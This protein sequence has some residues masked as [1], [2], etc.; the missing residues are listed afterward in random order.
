MLEFDITNPIA[1]GRTA[2]IFALDERYVLKLFL[3]YLPDDE[4][5]NEAAL[6]R[7]V[8]QAGVKTPAAVEVVKVNGRCGIVMERI[9]GRSM[10]AHLQDNLNE[11]NEFAQALAQLHT[12]LHQHSSMTLVPEHEW[13]ARKI[14]RAQ[15]LRDEMKTAVLAQLQHLPHEDI[16]CHGDF[17]MDNIIITADGPVVIDWCNANRGHPLSDVARTS[18]MLTK[19]ALPPNMSPAEQAAIQELRAAFNQIYLDHYFALQL[20]TPDELLP[21]HLPV[22]AARLSETIPEET[23]VLVD[24]VQK[25]VNGE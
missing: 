2:E 21:W 16:I 3:P 18:L 12:E 22:T 20:Y 24:D 25:M 7:A 19:G 6:I 4:A 5:E 15:P 8:C 9:E 1:A 11:I 17:H 10:L 13:L 23:A 14:K